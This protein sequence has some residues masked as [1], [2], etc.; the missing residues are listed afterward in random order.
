MGENGRSPSWSPSFYVC[1]K[2][3]RFGAVISSRVGIR[4]ITDMLGMA[5]RVCLMDQSWGRAP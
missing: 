1:D 5:D 2:R 3:P 4:G